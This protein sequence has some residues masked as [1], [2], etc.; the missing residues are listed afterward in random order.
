M[1]PYPD[2]KW[3]H[4]RGCLACED[5]GAKAANLVGGISRRFGSV[6]TRASY[7]LYRTESTINTFLTHNVDFGLLFPLAR[8]MYS[9]IQAR[10]QRG[11]NQSAN[12][13][14]INLWMSF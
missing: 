4:G 1:Y 7:Q 10:V 9:T 11:E 3:C 12:S 8:R 14:F 13:I 2:C 6:Q 5:E